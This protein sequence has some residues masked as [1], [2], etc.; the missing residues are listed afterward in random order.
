MQASRLKEKRHARRKAGIRKR[1]QGTAECPRLTVYRSLKH[2]HA[3]VIDD[4]AGKTLAA[5][6]TVGLVA[7]KSG[8]KNAAEKVGQA[9]AA[10]AIAA[11]VTR[12]AFD[13]NGFKYHGRIKSFADAA[14]KAG[15][16]F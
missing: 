9:L 11:G 12:V 10:K 13:R 14:R 6:T 15:L 16:K 4:I 7:D 2:F 1:V 8:N 3:Q 5:A